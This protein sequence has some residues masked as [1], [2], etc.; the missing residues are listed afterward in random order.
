MLLSCHQLYVAFNQSGS[1]RLPIDRRQ[2]DVVLLNGRTVQ[3]TVEV[4]TLF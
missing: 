3:F 1:A 2:I 4:S